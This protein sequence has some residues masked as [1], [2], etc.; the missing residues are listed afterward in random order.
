M[1]CRDCETE[2]KEKEN[3]IHP[4]SEPY[5]SICKTNADEQPDSRINEVR[6]L[7]GPA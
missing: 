7:H 3:C 1:K 6:K 2:I 4:K 5:C